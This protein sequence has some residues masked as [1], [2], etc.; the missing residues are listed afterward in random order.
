MEYGRFPSIQEM[1]VLVSLKQEALYYE[2][3]YIPNNSTV[4]EL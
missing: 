2:P 1:V 4:K 3:F